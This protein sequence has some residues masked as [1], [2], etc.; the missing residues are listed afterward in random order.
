VSSPRRLE[1]KVAIVTGGARGIGEASARLFAEHGA[2]V[3]VA[4]VN[5]VGAR[6]VAASIV[7]DGG[8][9]VA[10]GVDVRDERRCAAMAAATLDAFGAVDVLHTCAA[11]VEFAPVHELGTDSWA[12]VVD[13]NAKGTYLACKAVLPA[14]LEQGAGAIVVMASVSGTHGQPHFAAYNASK[15]AVVALTR[16]LAVDYGPRIRVNCVSPGPTDTPAVREAVAAAPDPEG[17]LRELEASNH[18]ARRLGRPREI[19]YAALFLASDEASFCHG[20]NLL[21]AGGQTILP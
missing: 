5:E 21:V 1:G 10:V 8:E 12:R 17:F 13:T 3:A 18:V 11:V 9:A 2:R 20:T 4:D 15:G 7:H 19:A 14:M 6:D 16:N